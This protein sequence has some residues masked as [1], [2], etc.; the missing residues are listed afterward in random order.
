MGKYSYC[1]ENE[2]VNLSPMQ[3][4]MVF[5]SLKYYKMPI[6]KYGISHFYRFKISDEMIKKVNVVPDGSVDIMFNLNGKK[7]EAVCYGSPLALNDRS[8]VSMLNNNEE[9]FG[10]RFLPGNNMMPGGCSVSELTNSAVDLSDLISNDIELTEKII[11]CKDFNSQIK[12]FLNFYLEEYRKII[13]KTKKNN[14]SEYIV[15]EIIKNNGNLRIEVLSE[16][17]GFSTRYINKLFNESFGMSPKLFSKIIRFQNTLRALR[18]NLKI[19]DIAEIMGFFDQSHLG[20]EFKEFT[21][22]TPKRFAEVMNT[23]EYKKRLILI[24]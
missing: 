23:D 21:G 12:I 24:K 18:G 7:P 11:E 8:Y 14:L 6:M 22:T 17:L 3:P 20:K 15:S 4:L 9:V 10:V 19:T 16:K 13:V 5:A 2:K 1:D